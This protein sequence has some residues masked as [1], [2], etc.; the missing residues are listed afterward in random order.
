MHLQFLWVYDQKE[1]AGIDKNFVCSIPKMQLIFS[2]EFFVPVFQVQ[3]P[4]P[5][6]SVVSN[7][8]IVPDL[9]HHAVGHR[10]QETTQGVIWCYVRY[11]TI[12]ICT[13]T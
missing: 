13:Q 10:R 7:T 11:K 9:K 6:V 5:G 8:K 4:S 12:Y 3:L 1:L 2:S